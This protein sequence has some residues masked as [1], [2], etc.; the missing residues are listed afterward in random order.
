MGA[1]DQLELQA[2]RVQQCQEG[3]ELNT[4][5]A[6][7]HEPD[8]P[9]RHSGQLGEIML[10]QPQDGAARPDFGRKVIGKGRF[11]GKPF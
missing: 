2:E 11:D 9:L 4:R 1:G 5:F 3:V 10:R 7:F 6:L 8:E